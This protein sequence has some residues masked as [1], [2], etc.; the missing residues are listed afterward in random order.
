VL[1]FKLRVLDLLDVFLKNAGTN[2]LVVGIIPRLL[3]LQKVNSDKILVDKVSSIL[4][5]RYGNA[6]EYPVL[7]D[8]TAAMDVLTE[9]HQVCNKTSDAKMFGVYANVGVYLVKVLLR[10]PTE[11]LKKKVHLN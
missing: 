5:N 7:E 10:K 4:Q 9:I 1:H 3:T 2:A 8:I 6:K 11:P